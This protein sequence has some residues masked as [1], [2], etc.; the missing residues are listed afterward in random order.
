MNNTVR[1]FWIDIPLF[2][3]DAILHALKKFKF[4]LTDVPGGI[5]AFL[6]K[7]RAIL[8]TTPL[9]ILYNLILKNKSFPGS[10][11][12]SK[13]QPVLRKGESYISTITVL[14]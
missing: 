8:F 11:K 4:K 2:T 5:P 9:K 7:D 14:L 6:L 13:V 3:E 12:I 1:Y 10:W